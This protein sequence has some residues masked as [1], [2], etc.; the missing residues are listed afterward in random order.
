MQRRIKS[1]YAWLAIAGLTIITLILYTIYPSDRTLSPETPDSFIVD[2]PESQP[3]PHTI[4]LTIGS[5]DPVISTDTTYFDTVDR[6]T[7]LQVC[8][9]PN[10]PDQISYWEIITELPDLIS[11]ECELAF[12]RYLDSNGLGQDGV[13]QLLSTENPMSYHRV[14]ANPSRDRGLV[15]DALS[16]EECRLDS[17]DLVRLDLKDTCHAQAFANHMQFLRLCHAENNPAISLMDD[18]KTVDFLRTLKGDPQ[19]QL[20]IDTKEMTHDTWIKYLENKWVNTECNKYRDNKQLFTLVKNRHSQAHEWLHSI[21]TRL[22]EDQHWDD[23]KVSP[24]LNTLRAISARLGDEWAMI[25]YTPAEINKQWYKFI[26]H[27]QIGLT[28]FKDGIELVVLLQ[29]LNIEINWKRLVQHLCT[30]K[31]DGLDCQLMLE[32]LNTEVAAH[33]TQRLNILDNIERVALELNIYN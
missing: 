30:R 33:D 26:Q 28:Q 24:V 6:E 18:M 14:F 2:E 1:W 5:L 25:T 13:F 9:I 10:W 17:T 27:E 19:N 29:D 16:K 21:A 22:G 11:K 15:L 3:V 12:D 23:L 32:Q 4:T 7:I 31:D 8:D 20:K